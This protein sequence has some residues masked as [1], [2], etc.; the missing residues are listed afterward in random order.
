MLNSPN[1]VLV[2]LYV[3][4]SWKSDSPTRALKAA[5]YYPVPIFT[6]VYRR[7]SAQHSMW[8]VECTKVKTGEL[9][10]GKGC[11]KVM[12]TSILCANTHTYI[13]YEVAIQPVKKTKLHGDLFFHISATRQL[14]IVP[15]GQYSPGGW[16]S[17]AYNT[18]FFVINIDDENNTAFSYV[19]S[20]NICHRECIYEVAYS[21]ETPLGSLLSPDL[22]AHNDHATSLV[23]LN[24]VTTSAN[25]SHT[26]IYICISTSIL[27]ISLHFSGKYI[28]QSES[29]WLLFTFQLKML[30]K[31][32]IC[33]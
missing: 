2:V 9:R 33:F 12:T 8:R 19:L 22:L 31:T 25:M 30:H 24:Q 29:L 21:T 14:P 23:S 6:Y 3:W 13:K 17:H 27:Y 5:Q 28:F 10:W 18:A 4:S 15:I 1:I 16:F 32:K 11:H 26:L 20:L 7:L